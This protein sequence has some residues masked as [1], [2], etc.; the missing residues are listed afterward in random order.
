MAED[1][2]RKLSDLRALLGRIDQRRLEADDWAVVNALISE[3]I[4]QAEPGSEIVIIELSE[5]EKAVV[6][7]TGEAVG[8]EESTSECESKREA[9]DG[10]KRLNWPR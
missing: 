10:T 2:Y 1:I 3:V 4:D 5:E 8:A 9:S 7:R 6:G